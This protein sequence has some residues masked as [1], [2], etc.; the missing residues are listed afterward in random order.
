[1]SFFENGYG[2]GG[3]ALQFNPEAQLDPSQVNFWLGENN[4]WRG[5]AR[6]TLPPFYDPVPQWAQNN[7]GSGGLWGG[8]WADPVSTGYPYGPAFDRNWGNFPFG[9]MR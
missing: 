3:D 1:M 2:A 8:G 5:F 9:Q 7:P 4:P 6:R